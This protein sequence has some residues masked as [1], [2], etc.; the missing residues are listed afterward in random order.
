M[1]MIVDF[2]FQSGGGGCLLEYMGLLEKYSTNET[3]SKCTSNEQKN[4]NTF[5]HVKKWYWLA[6]FSLCIDDQL[7]IVF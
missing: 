2:I 3:E 5:E 7:E 1:Y 4:R 6:R